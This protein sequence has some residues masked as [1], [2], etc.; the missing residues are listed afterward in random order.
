MNAK[1]NKGDSLSKDM[2]GYQSN[3]KEFIKILSCTKCNN[4]VEFRRKILAEIER[5]NPK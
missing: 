5:L 4:A 2:A 3:F 1:A